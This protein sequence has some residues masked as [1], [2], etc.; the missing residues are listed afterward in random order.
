M[1]ITCLTSYWC[2][3]RCLFS[4]SIRA[5]H[6]MLCAVVCPSPVQLGY[7]IA[8][9][10]GAVGSTRAVTCAA[11][12]GYLCLDAE[13]N[14]ATPTSITCGAQGMH[15]WEPPALGALKRRSDV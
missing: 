7:V 9:G 1:Y 3:W 10:S 14:S 6:Y 2:L 4:G 11:S 8:S 12:W 13:G 15:D 5:L